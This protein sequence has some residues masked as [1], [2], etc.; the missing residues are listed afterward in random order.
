VTED[1]SNEKEV[2]II[3]V[4]IQFLY[5]IVAIRLTILLNHSELNIG[6]RF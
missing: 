2:H 5:T 3:E 6:A 4:F 1:V